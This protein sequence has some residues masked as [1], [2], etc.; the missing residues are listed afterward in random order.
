[1][2]TKAKGSLQLFH[3]LPCQKLNVGPSLFQEQKSKCDYQI[4]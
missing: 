4:F 2:G 1:M 3:T